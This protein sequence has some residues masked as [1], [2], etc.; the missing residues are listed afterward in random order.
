MTYQ[1]MVTKIESM[2]RFGKATGLE[3]STALLGK[4]EYPEKNMDIIHIAGTNGKGSTAAFLASLLKES[5][6]RV[7]LFTS[8]HLVT[9][10]ERIQVNGNYISEDDVVFWGE[11]VLEAARGLEVDAT[12]FD[13]ALAMALL[14]FKSQEVEVV[15]LETGLGGRFD[16]T[17]AL[18]VVPKVSVIT[19]IGFDHTAVLGNTLEEI[20]ENKADIIRKD[21]VAVIAKM[22]EKAQKVIVSHCEKLSVPYVFAMDMELDSKWELGLLGDYQK[23]NAQNALAAY[24]SYMKGKMDPEV[25]A[26]GLKNA[27]HPGRLQIIQKDPLVIVDGAHN[28]QGVSA[29]S[30]SLKALYPKEKFTFVVGVLADKD[31]GHMMEEMLP[32]AKEFVTVTVESNRALQGEELARYLRE[33]GAKAYAASSIEDAFLRE[34]TGKT[35]VFGSLYFVGD[36]I[37]YFKSM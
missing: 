13:I 22:D 18:S 28:P 29:L 2:R 7:G 8:P 37:Q 25:I 11:K 14:Y 21:T 26:L 20:A 12:M 27:T 9:F 36:V 16:S 34:Q 10:R 31:Y 3:V 19:N 6:K 4:L 32:L 30:R 24:E 33:R 17:R 23:E 1:Q 15:I 5:G 35:V